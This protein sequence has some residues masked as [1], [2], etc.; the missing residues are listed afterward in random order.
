M[1]DFGWAFVGG[2][3]LRDAGGVSGSVQYKLS[4]NQLTGSPNFVYS[5]QDDNLY[6]S[7][8]LRVSG[9]IYAHEYIVKI[10][11]KIVHKLNVSGST[12]FGDSLGDTHIYTGSITVSGATNFPFFVTS[13][14]KV[15]IGTLTPTQL[16]E[17]SGGNAYF[18]NDLSASGLIS[19]SYFY[20]DGSNLT[21]VSNITYT[22]PG[23]NRVLTSAGTD[24]ING[25]TNL[26]FNG[27]I[28]DITGSLNVSGT[29]FGL[30]VNSNTG[31]VG[32][33]TSSA[34]YALTVGGDIGIDQSI[35]HNNDTDT[36]IVFSDDR[37]NLWAG[38]VRAIDI[39]GSTSPPLVE[40]GQGG[41]DFEIK[42]N[43]G[44]LLYSDYSE[45]KIGIKTGAP[46]YDF[47]VSGTMAVSGNVVFQNDF[48]LSG[49]AEIVNNLSASGLIS[50]SYFYGDGSN[51]TGVTG[52]WDG[53]LYGTA[54]ITGS[55]IV[56]SS[57]SHILAADAI[58]NRVGVKTRTPTH[59]FSVS[60]TMAVSGNVL[61]RNDLTAS[62]LVSASYFY[63]D[64][65]NLINVSNITYT[66]PGDNR[67]LTSTGA[68]AINGEANLFFDGSRL[69]ITGSMNV[70][71]TYPALSVDTDTGTVG[72]NTAS[73]TEALTVN[74]N[75]G[76]GQSIIHNGDTD[77]KLTYTSDR[78][79]FYAGGATTIDIR[80]DT[81]PKRLDVEQ[82][83]QVNGAGGTLLYADVSEDKI[84]IKTTLPSH[85]FSVSGTMAVS[86][87]VLFQNEVTA[88]GLMSA[89][90]FYGD[91]SNLTGVT[92][93]WDG[94]LYGTASITGSLIISS[95]NSDIFYANAILNRVGIKTRVPSHDFSVS[96]TMAVSGN[97][98]FHNQVTASG[99]VSASYFYGDGSNL[100]NV[101]NITY[102]NP[103]DNRVITSTG[104]DAINGEANLFFDGSEFAVTGNLFVSGTYL[105]LTTDTD[106]GYVGI[107]TAAPNEALTVEG[108]IAI[109]QSL[110]HSGDTDTKLTYTSDRI[111]LTAGNESAIDIRG[112]T[113]PKRIDFGNYDVKITGSTSVL[114]FTDHSED[115]VGIG[116]TSPEE[117]LHIVS[118]GNGGVEI[119]NITGAP[120]LTFDMPSNEEARI[121]FK[122][123]TELRASIVWDSEAPSP[124]AMI[125]KGKGTNA[126]IMRFD[127]AGNVGIGTTNPSTE[128][129]VVGT[130]SGSAVSASYFYGDGS[131]IT[132]ITGEW[133]GSF[134]GSA[135]ITGSLIVSGSTTVYGSL[136]HKRRQI[137]STVTASVYDYFIGVSASTSIILQ[138]P[139]A[140][141]LTSGQVFI[142]KDEKGSAGTYPVEI[143][144]SSSQTID[145]NTSV[146]L[147][148]PYAAVNIYTN[149][150]D[151]F[152]IY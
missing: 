139:D 15:G 63:G 76:I 103:G 119:E 88:S 73:A 39:L 95:S 26:Y 51:L 17:V 120:T 71:G 144:A 99:L 93:E 7:G 89:S 102:T 82:D 18:T 118:T 149:G 81:N 117:P 33:N 130:I 96:G 125:F 80:G 43:S 131:G 35:I 140:A 128:L 122:E 23:D 97:T 90:Y 44:T 107:N 53:S 11:E 150:T 48:I 2:N 16:F 72:I 66:N 91:G 83:L 69:D 87:N 42:G 58:L 126:E 115:K 38:G 116:T 129:E 146:T 30:T 36:K 9:T 132:G 112:D 113:S 13:S 28:L 12:V 68:D 94:S 136:I 86:G 110:I 62:G 148:S 20:G 151:K 114:L 147:E 45:N 111:T 121:L 135:S 61:F 25:E 100:I 98:L 109:G 60:G 75:I 74:G 77:T 56:S 54:S 137:T 3:I 123:N 84:G 124:H 1:P 78:I 85:D 10:E 141:A 22:N 32:I 55:L 57:N 133:D 142:V 24:A 92:G 4:D 21:N 64:G 138:L 101:S 6:L 5:Q 29:Y 70:S 105:T 50:A 104:A 143:K 134:T 19:A 145:G 59:D 106:N 152:F 40:M 79:T 8:S 14:G 108:N 65:S 67:V 37:I 27:S 41:Y 49:S 34:T 52:E 47:S 127:P 31:M 46:D